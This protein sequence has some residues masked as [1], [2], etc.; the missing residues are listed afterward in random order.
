MFWRTLFIF[1]WLLKS[2]FVNKKQRRSYFWLGWLLWGLSVSRGRQSIRI[3]EAHQNWMNLSSS[4]LFFD[5]FQAEFKPQVKKGLQLTGIKNV[6][7]N[8]IKLLT[9]FMWWVSSGLTL[10]QIF[11][12]KFLFV[13]LNKYNHVLFNFIILNY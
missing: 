7:K 9:K 13:Y 4:Y 11:F 5:F 6:I 3:Q 12:F 10:S 2:V 8:N 1:I